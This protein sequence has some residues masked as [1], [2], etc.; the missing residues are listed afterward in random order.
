MAVGRRI[1]ARTLVLALFLA[2]SVAGTGRAQSEGTQPDSLLQRLER[3]LDSGIDAFTRFIEKIGEKTGDLIPPTLPLEDMPLNDLGG[4][5]Q[6]IVPYEEHFTLGTGAL[7]TITGE[8]GEIL[9][10]TWEQPVVRVKADITAGAE[11]VAQA[12]EIAESVRIDATPSQA[13]LDIRTVYP[14]RRAAEVNYAITVPKNAHVN[15]ANSYGNTVIRGVGGNVVVKS[16]NGRVE[17][18]DLARPVKVGALGNFPLFAFGLRQG[19]EFLLQDSQAEFVNVSGALQI[20]IF[21]GSVNLRQLASD[22]QVRVTSNGGPVHLHLSRDDKPYIEASAIFGEVRSDIEL[23]RTVRPTLIEAR[24][25]NVEAPQR[26]IV[27]NSFEDVYVHLEGMPAVPSA[28][29][30]EG[31]E[32]FAEEVPQRTVPAP[33]TFALEVDSDVGD[34]RIEPADEEVITLS[35]TKHVWVQAPSHAPSALQALT[36]HWPPEEAEGRL[37]LATGVDPAVDLALLDCSAYR[38]DLVITCPRTMAVDIRGQ[39]GNVTLT[40]LEGPVKVNVGEGTIN[41]QQLKGALEASTGKG[42]IQALDCEDA[43]TLTGAFGRLATRNG[44]GPQQITG[45]QCKVVVDAPLGP[46]TVRNTSGDVSIIALSGVGGN[47][48]VAV[49]QGD[50][51]IMLLPTSDAALFVTAEHGHVDVNN[52][53]IL[54]VTVQKDVQRLQGSM[55]NGLHRVV[56]AAKNG[57]IAVD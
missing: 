33:P 24:S 29:R 21:M 32:H 44:K 2:L 17:L 3:G 16:R 38:I 14:E 52:G 27:T 34:I 18:R 25:T 15:V 46:L 43:L 37:R 22:A 13:G 11:T 9:V 35:A 51:S 42:D 23:L 5:E 53:L 50:L 26:V 57:N 56:L 40:G 7:V 4:P 12:F 36:V 41:A 54:S 47:Y 8:F 20:G 1:A 39:S 48:D 28:P 19:G 6:A 49:D 10:D 45:Q 30:S 55:Q 31:G